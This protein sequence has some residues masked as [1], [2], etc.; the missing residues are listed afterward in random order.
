MARRGEFCGKGILQEGASLPGPK[1]GLLSNIWKWIAH[2][3]DTCWQSKR[4]YREESSR[5][6]SSSR[7][8]ARWLAVSGFMAM[9]LVSGLSQANHCAWPIFGVIQG[10][11][12]WCTHLSA[13]MDSNVRASGRLAGHSIS[14]LILLAPPYFSWLNIEVAPHSLS[15]PPVVV[16]ASRYHHAWLEQVVSVM[17]FPTNMSFRHHFLS[18]DSSST[19]C[20][21]E[22]EALKTFWR[23]SLS[24]KLGREAAYYILV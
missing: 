13:K 1:S 8:S 18:K 20:S 16:H 2:G 22:Q 19:L 10:P 6:K 9:R 3:G 11:S 15:G 12:Q 7:P 14:S 21:M 23:K 5:V 4:F 24:Y 17:G